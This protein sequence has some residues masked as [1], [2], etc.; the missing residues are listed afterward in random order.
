MPAKH[1]APESPFFRV[2]ESARGHVDA[3]EF[4]LVALTLV[5]LRATREEEWASLLAAPPREAAFM[6][7]R[8]GREPKLP[9][10]GNIRAIC[11]LLPGAALTE[12]LTAIDSV[13][14]QLG[15]SETFQLL[16]DELASNA[17]VT[18]G[19]YTP[20]AV[21]AALARMLD[22]ALAPTVYDPFCR[23]G[24]LLI[25]VAS[26]VRAN[27]PHAPLHVYGNMPNSGSLEIARM[28]ILLHE[29]DG[30][31][32]RRDVGGQDAM[33][34]ETR[35]FSRIVSNPPF[36]LSNW[37][38][39]NHRPWRYGQPPQ[40]NANFVW[41]QDAVEGLEPGGRASMIMANSAASSTNRTEKEIRMRMVE[42][43]C[44]EALISLPPAL[45]HGTGVPA[46]IWLLTPPGTPRDEILFIDASSAGHMVSRT[47]RKLEDSEVRE[48]VQIVENWRAG[49]PVA[50]NDGTIRGGSV[51]LQM[52]RNL[53][54]EL[55]PAN[56]LRRPYAAPRVEDALPE[57]HELAIK[58]GA[59]HAIAGDRDSAVTHLVQDPA[60]LNELIS[61][62][63]ADWPAVR[64]A[65]LCQLVPGTPTH[66]APDG[67][68][69]VLKPKNL[70]LGRLAGPTDMLSTKEAQRLTRYQV[71]SGDLLCT[72][73]GTVG[74]VGL[75][76]QKQDGW[77]FGTGLIRIRAKPQSLVDPLFLNFYFTHPAVADWIQRNARG[78]SIPNISSQV[79]GT[80]PVWLPSLSD[81]R[82]IGAALNK[83][84]ESIEAHQ[85]VNETT[86]ELRN[87]LLPLLMSR[88]LPT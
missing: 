68:V 6:L 75:A 38:R 44:V 48:I 15:D 2:I 49:R 55:N 77:I 24:E 41:L 62:A 11:D 21:T 71:R 26:D 5:F 23:A 70:A 46:M 42:D 7:E 85:R 3:S 18:G 9:I 43:G 82:A 53:D 83:L 66:D 50:E 32:G 47:L 22:T 1:E 37:D 57:V 36:N 69:P 65:D 80:L 87:A 14:S 4:G 81:Q 56:F 72:R 52:I 84:N 35:R 10:G 40:H 51:S 79:L 67:S 88:E 12:T 39:G 31:L 54:Y 63:S 30:E 33:F 61:S 34:W 58:L 45:F 78:T 73:T 29:V 16:L 76:S 8:L 27:F 74:R 20:K 60:A 13:A 25:A 19:V 64:L 28:N 17:K 59:T 86:A